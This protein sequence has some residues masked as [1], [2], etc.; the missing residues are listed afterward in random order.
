MSG[1]NRAKIVTTKTG[2]LRR[3][4]TMADQSS[5]DKTGIDK[6]GPQDGRRGCR[7]IA[8]IASRDGT[9]VDDG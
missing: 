4:E 9:R 3:G 7:G 6:S 8:D 1:A 5:I 2:V